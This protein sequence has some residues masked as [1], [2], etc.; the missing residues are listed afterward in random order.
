MRK[1]AIRDPLSRRGACGE[2]PVGSRIGTTRPGSADTGQAR[3]ANCPG[4]VPLSGWSRCT[5]QSGRRSR[6]SALRRDR[7]VLHAWA[8]LARDELTTVARYLTHRDVHV[9]GAPDPWLDCSAR[10]ALRPS[11]R[12]YKRPF[13]RG[14]RGFGAVTKIGLEG[15]RTL[16]PPSVV[17]PP[18]T[19]VEGRR[20]RGHPSPRRRQTRV[21][22]PRSH[23]A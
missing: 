17:E 2:L 19:Q 10:R 4:S 6:K 14:S 7:E 8:D 3:V 23:R 15:T 22:W 18:A 11:P 20:R 5:A 13:C 1:P 21:R 9:A 16:D 12:G